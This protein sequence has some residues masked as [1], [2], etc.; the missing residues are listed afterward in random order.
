MRKKRTAEQKAEIIGKSIADGA[1]AVDRLKKMLTD[2]GLDPALLA[3]AGLQ[4][5][6]FLAQARLCDE[7]EENEKEFP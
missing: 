2:C 1:E 4:V 3:S 5:G 7:D 6:L